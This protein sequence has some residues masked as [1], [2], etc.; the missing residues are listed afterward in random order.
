[1]EI[2]LVEPRIVALGPR[3]PVDEPRHRAEEK[4]T[5]ALCS[6]SAPVRGARTGVGSVEVKLA[7]VAIDRSC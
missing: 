1:M 2:A 4:K 5:G 7:R 6:G 3:L